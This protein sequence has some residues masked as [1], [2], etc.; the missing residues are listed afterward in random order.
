MNPT[1]MSLMMS[2]T[3]QVT[4]TTR[5]IEDGEKLS[6]DDLIEAQANLSVLYINFPGDDMVNEL[7]PYADAVSKELKSR[8]H[9]IEVKHD[10]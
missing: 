7:K 4:E 10:V 1:F 6:L 8:G 2:T 5:R 3:E 9:I